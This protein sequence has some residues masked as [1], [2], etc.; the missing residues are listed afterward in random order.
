[1]AKK[2]IICADGTWNTPHGPTGLP[3]DTNV[4]KLYLMLV[5]D[6]TQLKYYDSGVGTDGTPFEHFFG[7]AMGEGLFEKV[8]DGY[9]FVSYVWDPGDD[10]YIFGFSRGAYTARSL[11]GMLAAFGV[12]TKNL[13]N[14]TVKRV[15]DAYR[16]SDHGERLKAKAELSAEYGLADVKVRMVGVWDTVGS[17][18]IPGHLFDDFDQ[19]KYGFLDTALNPCI[20]NAYHAIS[21]DERRASFSPTLWTNPDGS[22]RDNDEQVQQ[23]WFPGVHCDVGGSYAQCDLSNITL[24]WM[25]DNAKTCGLVFDN[26]VVQ[27]CLPESYK[28]LGAAHD[29]WKLIP[30]GLPKSRVAPSKA[31]MSNTVKLRLISGLGYQTSALNLPIDSYK[32]ALVIPENEIDLSC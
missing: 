2:V 29:E 28:P 26:A 1:M 13:D 12:P 8:Q 9:G 11:A 3:D 22:S 19:A 21:L 18:G 31:V 6:A 4:R 5:D 30:W 32:Q 14:R 20:Q 15:F 7:G 10:I 25:I 27:K 23:V 24:R 17:L 16:I